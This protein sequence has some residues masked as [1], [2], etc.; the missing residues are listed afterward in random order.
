M[1]SRGYAIDAIDQSAGQVAEAERHAATRGCGARFR[2]ADAER[3]PWPD[4]TFDFAYSINVI[5]HVTPIAKRGRVLAEIV[6]V[7]KP[8]G[9]F[10]LH[11]INV[12]NPLFRFYMSYCFPLLCDIDEGTEEWIRPSRL[13]EVA[14]A[15]WSPDVDYF[16][17][18]PDF[19]PR[20][21][22]DALTGV[23]ARLER[24]AIRNWSAHYVAC[25]RR[26]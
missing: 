14:G 8:G 17:F 25:L 15:A 12:E 20:A 3:L 26:I 2:T 13:P 19:T 1:A 5:H 24:S 9:V 16:T 6:R 23:E 21:V 11:E 4:G 10:F 7:L 18:L 22:L